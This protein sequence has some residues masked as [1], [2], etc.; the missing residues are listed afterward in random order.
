MVA[1]IA[2]LLAAGLYIRSIDWSYTLIASVECGSNRT[3]NIYE[4]TFCDFATIPVYDVEVGGR[5]SESK[6]S[7]GLGMNVETI[8]I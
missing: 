4:D 6:Y 5:K 1:G 7:T 8:S 2:C 3:I